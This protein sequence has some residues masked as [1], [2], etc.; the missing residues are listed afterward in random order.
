[1]MNDS[2]EEI[3]LH[4]RFKLLSESDFAAFSKDINT[5]RKISLESLAACNYG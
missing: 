2:F 3:F 4:W 5:S 1:M